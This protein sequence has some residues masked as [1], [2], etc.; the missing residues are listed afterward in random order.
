ML[1]MPLAHPSTLDRRTESRKPAVASSFVEELWSPALLCLTK[2]SQAKVKALFQLRFSVPKHRGTF[3]SRAGPHSRLT[4]VQ[5]EHLPFGDR[6]SSPETTK[7]TRWVALARS[8]HAASFLARAPLSE[9]SSGSEPAPVVDGQVPARHRDGL[10]RVG[11]HLGIDRFRHRLHGRYAGEE[12]RPNSGCAQGSRCRSSDHSWHR[13]RNRIAN[14]SSPIRSLTRSAARGSGPARSLA[15]GPHRPR[16][17]RASPWRL[18]R[19]TSPRGR[20]PGR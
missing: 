17:D 19:R 13:R 3:L 18:K 11:E 14:A 10:G 20:S 9:G 16:P 12:D 8:C 15:G 2:K 1:S 7:A 5:A 6:I 4:L